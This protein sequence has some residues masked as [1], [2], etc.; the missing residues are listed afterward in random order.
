VAYSTTPASHSAGNYGSMFWLNRGG[1]LPSAPEDMFSCNG[2]DGQRIFIIPSADLVVVVLG[3]SHRPEN[4]LNFNLLLGDIL[5]S[6][7]PQ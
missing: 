6:L 4:D 2:Y 3:H 1:L 7:Q 5:G